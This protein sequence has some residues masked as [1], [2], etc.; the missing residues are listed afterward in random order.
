M[1]SDQRTG[2]FCIKLNIWTKCLDMVSSDDLILDEVILQ[3]FEEQDKAFH[4]P[5]TS[6]KDAR[7]FVKALHKKGLSYDCLSQEIREPEQNLSAWRTGISRP[8]V[9]NR[10]IERINR[11][12]Q[13]VF[14]SDGDDDSVCCDKLS[15]C[16]DNTTESGETDHNGVD[17]FHS[18][19]DQPAAELKYTDNRKIVQSLDGNGVYTKDNLQIILENNINDNQGSDEK[20]MVKQGQDDS[21]EITIDKQQMSEIS[22]ACA[23]RI[24]D[25]EVKKNADIVIESIQNTVGN[26]NLLTEMSD[27]KNKDDLKLIE[28]DEADNKITA[29]ETMNSENEKIKELVK[30]ETLHDV[31]ETECHLTLATDDS[32]SND[33][34]EKATSLDKNLSENSLKQKKIFSFEVEPSCTVNSEDVELLGKQTTDREFVKHALSYD[35]HLN[36]NVIQEKFEDVQESRYVSSESCSEV[37]VM[38]DTKVVGDFQ[39]LNKAQTNYITGPPIETEAADSTIAAMNSAFCDRSVETATVNSY[40]SSGDVFEN[41]DS[42]HDDEFTN[43]DTAR[44]AERENEME[45]KKS[46]GHDSG[47]IYVFTDSTSDDKEF[48]VKVGASRFPHKKLKQALLFNVDMRLVSAVKVCHRRKAFAAVQQQLS[49]CAIPNTTGWFRG[50]MDKIL[51]VLMDA[52]EGHSVQN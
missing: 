41:Y 12:L 30:F 33:D 20:V 19:E 24:D 46:L 35:Q 21:K 45:N 7:A 47:Y 26:D 51:K 39:H 25:G 23:N 50:P 4:F 28:T 2:A 29:E 22:D 9:G 32:L 31:T 43:D 52:K 37:P 6:Q 15:T 1:T 17:S 49:E 42:D 5:V 40:E 38:N 34:D 36:D 11:P 10:I 8:R 13:E 18:T 16:S 3:V 14:L 48:R 27:A 44:V